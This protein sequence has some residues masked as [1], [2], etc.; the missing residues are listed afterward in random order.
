MHA[1]PADE[2]LSAVR[3]TWETP[4]ERSIIASSLTKL[5]HTAAGNAPVGL[6][7][8]NAECFQGFAR[9]LCHHGIDGVG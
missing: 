7:K 5:A 8:W 9:C 6:R 4:I 3:I 2:V 1:Y